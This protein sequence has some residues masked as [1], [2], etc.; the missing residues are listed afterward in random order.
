[1]L[2]CA[3]RIAGAATSG[4]LLFLASALHA[5]T[6]SCLPSVDRLAEA[7]ADCLP[8]TDEPCGETLRPVPH[9][10]VAPDRPGSGQ[11]PYPVAPTDGEV[12]RR[13]GATRRRPMFYDWYTRGASLPNRRLATYRLPWLG[14]PANARV[15]P[16]WTPNPDLWG[17]V[18]QQWLQTAA[19][20]PCVVPGVEPDDGGG[21]P[22]S[23]G[24]VPDGSTG[25]PLRLTK[26][27][28]IPGNLTLSWG[29][30]CTIGGSDYS[31]HQGTIGNWYSHT[32]L[33]CSTAGAR[34]RT[35]MLGP[36]DRYYLIVPLNTDAEG[37]YGFGSGGSHRPVSSSRC[38]TVRR[39]A[40]P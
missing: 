24:V 38:R 28:A 40:C 26:N 8:E 10:W 23:A 2:K 4:V 20:C 9:P 15:L 1:L 32:F 34:S 16:A 11:G 22:T 27:S 33:V 31:I 25:V 18:Q 14:L 12:L 36:G 13:M 37:G 19:D 39:S 17:K 29:A 6:A 21:G 7:E 5:G 3:V 30:S 35:I